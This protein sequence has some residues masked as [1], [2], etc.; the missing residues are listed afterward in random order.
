MSSFFII[1]K[2]FGS[3]KMQ[4]FES[5]LILHIFSSNQMDLF[6]IGVPFSKLINIARAGR[7]G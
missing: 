6:Y 7:I 3:N 2:G 5:N 1:Y 4:L